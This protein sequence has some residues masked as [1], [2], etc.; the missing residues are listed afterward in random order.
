MILT[1]FD[2]VLIAKSSC[3][4]SYKTY[5]QCDQSFLQKNNKIWSI[6]SFLSKEIKTHYKLKQPFKTDKQKSCFHQ[7]NYVIK[8][9]F[10]HLK[11]LQLCLQSADPV[12]WLHF[13]LDVSLACVLHWLCL[14]FNGVTGSYN[15]W[16]LVVWLVERH[17]FRELFFKLHLK[18]MAVPCII[19]M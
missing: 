12:G 17:F 13:A 7:L 4:G 15:V 8:T 18:P 2:E 14:F 1:L 11:V 3:S 6:L 16:T 10:T 5:I 19:W 9:P